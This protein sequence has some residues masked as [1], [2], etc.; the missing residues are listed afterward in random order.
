MIHGAGSQD[1]AL[2]V[3]LSLFLPA[4]QSVS[5]AAPA[6]GRRFSPDAFAFAAI[7]SASG[8][9]LTGCTYSVELHVRAW[10]RDLV[11]FPVG[12]RNGGCV[13]CCGAGDRF[14]GAQSSLAALF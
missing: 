1:P 8:Y 14:F 6:G 5:C 9:L 7:G 2:F 13:A 11:L 12:D 10:W 4:E 3:C